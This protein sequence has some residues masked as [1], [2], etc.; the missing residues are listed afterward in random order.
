MSNS[1]A[2]ISNLLGEYTHRL[3][4]GDLEGAAELFR[5]ARIQTGP[6]TWIDHK[7]LLQVWRDGV[8]LFDDGTPRTK[9]VC[10]NAV[11]DIDEDADSASSKSYYVVYQQTA[12]LPLQAIAAGRY[13]DS[14]ERVEGTWRFSER[15]YTL[16]DHVGNMEEHSN[17]WEQIKAHFLT[18]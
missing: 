9:H 1:Y 15:N 14:F 4:L 13:Y 18:T 8:K 7:A 10:S 12:T 11:I 16:L 3:D 6:E 2:E 17:S 5:Y